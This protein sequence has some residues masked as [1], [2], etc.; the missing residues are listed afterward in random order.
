MNIRITD[1]D[2]L[3]DNVRVLAWDKDPSSQRRARWR[4]AVQHPG[5]ATGTHP[6]TL[7][8]TSADY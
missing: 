7:R 3:H 1:Q 6:G 4:L 8:G 2:R 5:T